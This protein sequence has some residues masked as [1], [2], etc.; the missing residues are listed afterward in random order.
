MVHKEIQ[1]IKDVVEREFLPYVRRPGRYIGGEVNQVVK[2]L[3][4]C[5]VRIALCFPD[6][7]EIGMSYLGMQVLYSIINDMEN[8]AAERVFAPWLD[9]EEV[10]RDKDIP[11]F[12]LESFSK[13]RDFDFIGFSLTNELC[14]TNL[15]NMLDLAGLEVRAENR[16]ENDPII[17]VGGQAANCA[18]PLSAFADMFVLGEGE[19]AVVELIDFYRESKK[20]DISKRD[21]LLACAKQFD[22]VYVPQFYNQN[23]SSDGDFL[24]PEYKGL[25]TEFQNAVVQDF[26]N[27]LIP[28]KPIVPF[29]QSVHE[30][31]SVEVMRGCP[32]RCRFCQASFCRRPVRIRSVDRIVDSAL[33]QYRATG[34]DTVS[35]LSLSTS[36]YPYLDE[37]IEKLNTVLAPLHVGLSLPS[38]KVQKQLQ[39]LPKMVTSVRKGGLTIAVEAASESLRQLINKPITDEDLFA[40]VQAA[41]GAGFLRVKLYF[42][43]GFPGESEQDILR[44]VDL[45]QELSSLRKDVDGKFADVTAAVSWLVPKAHTPF[46]WLGQKSS[47]YFKWAKELILARKR[48]LKLKFVKFNFHEVERSIL[49]S[50]MG[51]GDRRLCDVIETA[52]RKGAKFDLWDEGFD[53]TL[54]QQA[55]LENGMNLEEQAQSQFDIHSTVPWSHLGGPDQEYLLKH[56]HQATALLETK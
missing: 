50:A 22:F 25:R 51:R 8:V 44:I 19:D 11:L 35:L 21:F 36:D 14:Y 46:G 18:E 29:V 41:F 10:I 40:A 12:T 17:V 4:C 33:Q 30:R 31:V 6:I 38:L 45:S 15:L 27:A 56:Y 39:L 48:E 37:L 1:S 54:W 13:V 42:M 24:V 20:Q 5:D 7:Y 3:N 26:E 47:D 32:G 9:A 23:E 2:N 28:E 55:F 16:K 52:W 53:T 49:E 43:V 34:Y